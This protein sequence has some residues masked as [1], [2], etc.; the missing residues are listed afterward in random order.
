MKLLK[1]KLLF[2]LA[3]EL[4]FFRITEGFEYKPYEYLYFRLS[5]FEAGSVR[6]AATRLV[7]SG[8][9]DKITR[10][11]RALFRLT[12]TGREQLLKQLPVN[13]GRKRVWDR[14]WRVVILTNIGDESRQLKRRLNLLGY[15]RASRGVY[16]TPFNTSEA[17]KSLF[18]E[19]EWQNKAQV[20]ESRRIIVGDNL[21]LARTL[22]QLDEQVEKQAEFIRVS[23]R[24][25]K[26]ARHNIV[27]LR[28]SKN[29]FKGVFDR[30]Y[31][32]IISD[33][34]LPKKLLPSDWQAEQAKEWFLRLVELT[35]T[36]KI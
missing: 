11:N 7:K 29:G 22:W 20:I 31:R 24:L 10:A 33:P 28:Q 35:K 13:R 23:E 2:C 16:V 15:K 6:D 12:G 30:Y 3:S 26:L 36:A 8:A 32:L 27:L 21:K 25:L 34:G 9:L 5:E 18:L 19:P 1:S 14:I 17:T 4:D